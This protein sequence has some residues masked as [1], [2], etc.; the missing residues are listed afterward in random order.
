MKLI[1]N[2]Y[3]GLE[4]FHGRSKQTGVT[5]YFSQTKIAIAIDIVIEQN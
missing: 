5:P 1:K 3:G 4:T 2:P